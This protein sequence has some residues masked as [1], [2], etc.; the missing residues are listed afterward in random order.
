MELKDKYNPSESEG[1]WLRFWREKGFF[2]PEAVDSPHYSIVIPP[3]NVTDILH[4]GHALNNIIQDVL[5][6]Y[7]R[8][9]GFNT[10]WLP[11]TDHAGIA[12][13]NMVERE[14]AKEGK[15][16]EGIGKKRFVEMLYE[17]KEKKGNTILKQ[18]EEI[19]SSCDFS[20]TRFTLDEGFT[21]AVQEAFV[22]LY[23]EGLI[24]RG[25][26]IINWC[27]RCGTALSDDEVEH[28]DEKGQLWFIEYPFDDDPSDGVIVATTR[29]ETMLGDTAVAV[30]PAD[31]R[32][33]K[34]VGRMLKLP[35]VDDKRKGILDNE[36]VTVSPLIPIITDRA[37]STEFGTGAVKVT[38]AHDPNDYWIG[39]RAGVP[40][41]LVMNSDA[42]M[43]E[44]AGKYSGLDRYDAREKIVAELKEKGLLVKIEPHEHAVGHCYRCHTAIEPYL[45]DQWF[46]RMK[47]LA[48]PAIAAVKRGL[49]KLHPERWEGVYFNWMEN[50]RDWCISR[51]LWWGHQLPVWWCDDCGEFTVSTERPTRCPYCNSEKLH[52][53]E[54]V[55]DTWFSS[56]LWPFAT[57]GWPSFDAP[58]LAHFYPTD[59]LVTASEIIFFWVARM[60]MSSLHF[61]GE[62]PFRDVFIHGTVRDALGRK[63]SK[64]LGNGIDPME[65]VRLYGRDALRYT[66]LFQAASGQD[67]YIGKETGATKGKLSR[68]ELVKR[69]LASFEVGRNFTNKL[70]NAARLVLRSADSK[71]LLADVA[72]RNYTHLEDRYIL[73]VLQDST[74]DVR[75]AI[76]NFEL[77]EA[78]H[79]LHNFFWGEFCDWYLE[80]VKP[81]L[82]DGDADAQTVALFV[83]E[84]IIR[85]YHPF[86]PFVTEELWQRIKESGPITD[87]NN[88]SITITS[89]PDIIDRLQSAEAVEAFAI[90]KEIV[91]AVREIKSSFSLGMKPMGIL[92]I[93]PSADTGAVIDGHKE[94]IISLA[95][96][97]GVVIVDKKPAGF[98][99]LAM[100]TA[101]ELYLPLAGLV[102]FDKEQSRIEKELSR[103]SSILNGLDAKLTNEKFLTN[104]PP[105]IIESEKIKQVDL[106]KK[107]DKLQNMLSELRG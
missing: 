5:I 105:D 37:V 24:Y 101:G 26:Y 98:C 25:K 38:P 65:V 85:L 2:S 21:R 74:R 106:I 54:D 97:D 100:V 19:G 39:I 43:N 56:W 52:R 82:A 79:K 11:G 62:I 9:L 42:T 1:K 64:S 40:Q 102:D 27:P 34:M 87:L 45:S 72:N 57:M 96:L 70:W 63:M 95:K 36:E 103:V 30:H 71:F 32:Y 6:R 12:T 31:P 93:V 51:Q 17:W 29:P 80:A 81:R 15:S 59:T 78:M 86:I 4:L 18:L 50:I 61:V 75:S 8:M 92:N 20:R 48:E 84:R 107:K 89:Y 22:K 94:L 60:I 49:V 67:I 44:N 73:A 69:M 14:L 46:V 3:P 88:E 33:K 99:G 16:K 90:L 68:D 91:S 41:V 23:D 76:D 83:L 35:L 13:Q 28:E 58:D 77:G 47:P 104:A 7:H 10:L 53:D 55:L 66:I